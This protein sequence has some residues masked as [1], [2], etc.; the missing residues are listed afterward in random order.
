MD[1]FV[2]KMKKEMSEEVLKDFFSKG[3]VGD[4]KRVVGIRAKVPLF[5]CLCGTIF[6][7]QC[8]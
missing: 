7:S 4:K 6:Q 1:K 8:T 3:S 5:F 2:K